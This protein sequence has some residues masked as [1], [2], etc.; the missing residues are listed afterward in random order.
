MDK[1][2]LD[3]YQKLHTVHRLFITDC[4]ELEKR[5]VGMPDTQELADICYALR[6]VFTLIDDMRKETRKLQDYASKLFTVIWASDPNSTE[7]KVKTDWCTVSAEPKTRC[8]SPSPEKEPERYRDVMKLLGV[9]DDV[10]ELKALRADWD[11]FGDWL[12][13]M[14]LAGKAIP[15]SVGRTYTEYRVHIRS[16]KRLPTGE[17]SG[18][19]PNDSVETD[20]EHGTDESPF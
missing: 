15:D 6:E 8:S 11:S 1:K 5:I 17:S 19:E 13:E 3:V 9:P 16:R 7:D 14:Q 2:F 10:I 18:S 12:T 4:L 20:D